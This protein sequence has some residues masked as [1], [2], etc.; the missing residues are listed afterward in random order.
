MKAP[1]RILHALSLALLLF[2]FPAA[3]LAQGTDGTRC[4]EQGEVGVTIT[5]GL[6]AAGIPP[7]S[8]TWQT[9][10]HREIR[11]W[12]TGGLGVPWRVTI[13]RQDSG[14]VSGRHLMIWRKP[15]VGDSFYDAL[16]GRTWSNGAAALCEAKLAGEPDWTAL[17]GTLD[18]LG[19]RGIPANPV[20]C[21]FPTPG[22]GDRI[23]CG[24]TEYTLEYRDRAIYWSYGFQLYPDTTSVNYPRD[25]DMLRLMACSIREANIP[26][27]PIPGLDARCEA[28]S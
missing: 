10:G 20:A 3:A 24:V 27:L 6:V 22:S 9:H 12:N 11:Y 13:I 14:E 21:P 1:R 5:C 2:A 8:D 7:L 16:C 17:L 26:W 19:I 18:S 23:P 4:D 15:E 28:P 25:R